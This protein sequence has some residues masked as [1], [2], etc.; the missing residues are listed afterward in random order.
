MNFQ[1]A[2]RIV[3]FTWTLAV[4]SAGVAV[5]AEPPLLEAEPADDLV[6]AQAGTT[7]QG[8]LQPR[9]QPAPVE[10]EGAF[11]SDYLFGMTRGVAESAIHPAVKAPLF[12]L[13]VPLDIVFFPFAAIGGFFG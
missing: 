3:M 13:T 6:V 8:T 7:Q 5:A 2:R 10:E 1:R 12:L 9:Y 11:N 4:A